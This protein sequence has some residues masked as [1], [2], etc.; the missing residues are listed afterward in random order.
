M[1]GMLMVVCAG[2]CSTAIPGFEPKLS[3]FEIV[4]LS[5]A[6]NARRYQETFDEAFYDIDAHGDVNIILRNGLPNDGEH[7][8]MIQVIHVRS[9]WRSQPGR[10][11]AERTQLN[12]VIGYFVTGPRM[13]DA[14]EG[15]GSVFYEQDDEDVLTGSVDHAVVRPT[16]QV[17]PAEPIF[18]RAELKGKFRAVRDP[19]QVRQAINELQRRFGPLPPPVSK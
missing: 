2:G 19:R 13:G 15:T 1:A 5:D 10:T 16:R 3:A 6:G 8:P 17:A 12:A 4:D 7:D 9:V 18:T 14:L 11:T